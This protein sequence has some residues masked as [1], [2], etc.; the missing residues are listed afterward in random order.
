MRKKTAKLTSKSEVPKPQHFDRHQFDGKRARPVS[1][2]TRLSF[3][4]YVGMSTR[5]HKATFERRLPTPQWAL[6]DS[7]LQQLLVVFMEARAKIVNADGSM[8]QRLTR[9]SQAVINRHPKMVTSLALMCK[10]YRAILKDGVVD[11]KLKEPF[12]PGMEAEAQHYATVVRKR[13]LEI[14]I[15]GMDTYLRYTR[16]GGAD[17]LAAVVYLYYRVG[18]D[19][20]GV[21]AEVGL[22]PP[23]V[24]QLL[25]RLSETW[26]EK[27]SHILPAPAPPEPTPLFESLD[28]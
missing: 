2:E 6:D 23:H 15:E 8:F 10:E 12:L 22:K 18:M 19:S 4:D 9:A 5:A 26:K 14:E 7:L 1:Q 28:E 24:R 13:E 21:A 27:F 20:V 25:Y 3:E 17:M 11:P 16:T